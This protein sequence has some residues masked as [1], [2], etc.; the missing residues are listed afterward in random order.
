MTLTPP[1]L[2]AYDVGASGEGSIDPLSLAPTYDRL[3][4][5]LLPHLTVRMKRP[6]YLTAIAAGAHICEPMA[7]RLASD[8]RSP[9][10][11]VFEWSQRYRLPI[12][13]PYGR[14]EAFYFVQN[15]FDSDW[16]QAVFAFTSRLRNERPAGFDDIHFVP[17]NPR[18]FMGGL[19]WRF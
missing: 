11:I 10:W 19:A 14:L 12:K 1:L 15:L 3:A 2:S 8:G 5:R 16:E 13:L 9:A 6:R 7:D 4:N 18:T 17:G